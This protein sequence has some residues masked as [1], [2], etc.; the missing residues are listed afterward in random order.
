MAEG[1]PTTRRMA[2]AMAQAAWHRRRPPTEPGRNAHTWRW[3]WLEPQARA[4]LIA[5][6][7]AAIKAQMLILRP[8]PAVENG[9]RAV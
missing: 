8:R 4:E 9:G 7:E 5:D 6:M 2:E 3:E 1:P